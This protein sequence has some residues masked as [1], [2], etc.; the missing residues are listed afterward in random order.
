MVLLF[1]AAF[2]NAFGPVIS[3]YVALFSYH[4]LRLP[5]YPD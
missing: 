1:T 4:F 3:K 2:L 5:K